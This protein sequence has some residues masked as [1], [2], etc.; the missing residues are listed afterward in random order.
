MKHDAKVSSEIDTTEI[1]LALVDF[2]KNVLDARKQII[3]NLLKQDEVEKVKKLYIDKMYTYLD[4]ICW[5]TADSI[6][7]SKR[8][9]NVWKE[10]KFK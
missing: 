9:A 4:N 3:E 2:C 8:K 7:S 6:I 5:N 1:K 10:T